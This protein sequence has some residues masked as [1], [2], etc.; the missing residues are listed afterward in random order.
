M[1]LAR[2]LTPSSL[3]RLKKIHR[4]SARY[5]RRVGK[6]H[7]ERLL[8]LMAHHV[9]EIREL[10][11]EGDRHALIETGDLAVLCF[12][13]LL[14][15]RISPDRVMLKCFGRYERKLGALLAEIKSAR[16]RREKRHNKGKA[17]IKKFGK[18]M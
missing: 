15:Y 14:E 12:E 17:G 4:L 18:R 13:L 11:Q 6:R 7:P 16:N 8:E 10:R 1:S 5:N 3:Q 2:V 9:D